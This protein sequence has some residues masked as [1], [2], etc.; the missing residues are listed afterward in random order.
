VRHRPIVL[1]AAFIATALAQRA[2][3]A[4]DGPAWIAFSKL[5]ATTP[6]YIE[7]IVSHEV[8]GKATSDGTYR[9]TWMDPSNAKVEV[10]SGRAKGAVV[11]WT[12]GSKVQAHDVDN[13][14][15]VVP[16]E[17]MDKDATDLRGNPVGSAAFAFLRA[18]WA[19]GGPL[20]ETP[21]PVIDGVPTTIVSMNPDPS[22]MNGISKGDLYVAASGAPKR[23]V[24][25]EGT[26]LVEQDEFT[27]QNL[28]P[29]LSAKDFST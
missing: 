14:A 5:A 6:A 19:S 4:A 2:A 3:A 1:L 10:L 23:V 16:F 15:I 8:N 26:T 11:I 12:G 22:K 28:S 27:N 25:Y 7:T 18:V 21:G 29:K 9:F 17:R 20:T 24:L 13:P